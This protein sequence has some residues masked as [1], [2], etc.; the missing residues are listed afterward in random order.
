METT[1]RLNTT[2]YAV[3]G[4]LAFGESSGYDLARSAR[5]SIDYMWAPSRSQ[6]YKVLPRLV[7]RSLAERREVEQRSRPDKAL[8]RITPSG[9]TTLRSWV[10]HV[11]ED[12]PGGSAMFLLK[13]FFGWVAPPKA[14][15]AQLEAYTKL[16]EKN[17]GEFEEMERSPLPDEPVHSRL[18]LRHGIARARATLEWADEARAL[19][20]E[21]A[22]G[23]LSATRGSPR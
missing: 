9:L 10:E 8:F 18:A 1:E 4:L 22:G 23:G 11:E 6:I 20:G 12:P 3:L 13:L 19:L 2:E 15:R 5:R 17:L 14:A 16:L 7:D 21:P